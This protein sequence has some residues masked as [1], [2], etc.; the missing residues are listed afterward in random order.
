MDD[1]AGVPR[2]ARV[3]HDERTTDLAVAHTLMQRRELAVA[4]RREGHRL[5]RELPDGL[6]LGEAS[7]LAAARDGRADREDDPAGREPEAQGNREAREQMQDREARAFAHEALEPAGRIVVAGL[8]HR[9]MRQEVGESARTAMSTIMH[10]A[11]TA[12]VTHAR[13]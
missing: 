10:P 13:R 8:A 5:Q 7:R 9:S 6:A 12:T 11:I 1:L 2:L 4:G 3:L